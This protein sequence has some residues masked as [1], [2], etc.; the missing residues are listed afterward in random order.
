MLLPICSDESKKNKKRLI[1]VISGSIY[2]NG[3]IV[4]E[5]GKIL[6]EEIFQ[7]YNNK[8]IS[9][10]MIAYP[11]CISLEA[12]IDDLAKVMKIDLNKEKPYN[13]LRYINKLKKSYLFKIYPKIPLKL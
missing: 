4:A 2:E 11:D 9:D 13:I 10:E 7:D 8:N 6:G 3:N 12:S 5:K 1:I